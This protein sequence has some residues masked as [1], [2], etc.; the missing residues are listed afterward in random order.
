MTRSTTF[1]AALMVATT[2]SLLAMSAG[3]T[4]AR[5]STGCGVVTSAGHVWIVV[6]KAVPCSTAKRVT[7]GF[8]VRTAAMRSGQ[9]R[10]VASPLHGFTCLLASQGKPGG[11]CSTAG[12]TKSILWLV[13]S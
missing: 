10:I 5:A 12:A 13:A 1:P 11:S 3:A 2:L 8:A 7:R 4:T 9:K 6:A